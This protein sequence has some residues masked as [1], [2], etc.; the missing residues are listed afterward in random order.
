MTPPVVPSH[1]L[2]FKFVLRF[3]HTDRKEKPKKLVEKYGWAKRIHRFREIRGWTPPGYNV[4]TWSEFGP[5]C[6]YRYYSSANAL[7]ATRKEHR[8]VKRIHRFRKKSTLNTAKVLNRHVV[9]RK[10]GGKPSTCL[11]P[12]GLAERWKAR[13]QNKT[14][15][16][17]T[18][19]TKKTKT[20]TSIWNKIKFAK[21]QDLRNCQLHGTV[22]N[23]VC[24]P[25][26]AYRKQTS[27]R[28]EK[29]CK[30][31]NLDPQSNCNVAT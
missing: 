2:R 1:S 7:R 13:R 23:A 14:T 15:T 12:G 27:K 11:P 21:A 20:P 26:R 9:W 25:D 3:D 8:W 5:T 29:H 6:P 24:K 22:T 19:K 30:H 31:N 28:N 17:K 10:A 18:T 4:D 16:K